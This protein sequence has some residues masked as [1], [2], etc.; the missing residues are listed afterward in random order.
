MVVHPEAGAAPDSRTQA[1]RV[2]PVVRSRA[3]EWGTVTQS[4]TPSNDRALPDLPATQVAPEMVPFI[5]LPALLLTVVPDPSS[6]PNEAT[7]PD[8]VGLFTWKVVV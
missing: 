6:K 7:S 3:V 1:S 8:D 5:P 4:S 2:M